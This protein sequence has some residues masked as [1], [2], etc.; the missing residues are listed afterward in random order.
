MP[1]MTQRQV[2]FRRST[3]FQGVQGSSVEAQGHRSLDGSDNL[4]VPVGD[5]TNIGAQGFQESLLG[6]PARREGFRFGN[7]RASRGQGIQFPGPETAINEPVPVLGQQIRDA[8]HLHN[9][10]AQAPDAQ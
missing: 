4:Y 1:L 6:R 5:I 8:F 3:A 2:D 9:I 10:D 7:S